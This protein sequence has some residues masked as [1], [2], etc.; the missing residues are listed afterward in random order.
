MLRCCWC[1]WLARRALLGFGAPLSDAGK[2]GR[3]GGP[4]CAVWLPPVFPCTIG[5]AR[6][7]PWCGGCGYQFSWWPVA[8][9][10]L[11]C[12]GH[13]ASTLIPASSTPSGPCFGGWAG[14]LKYRCT[15]CSSGGFCQLAT[16]RNAVCHLG[17]VGWSCSLSVSA[18]CLAHQH[19]CGS[20]CTCS[21]CWH[22]WRG[23][24]GFGNSPCTCTVGVCALPGGGC[25]GR[26]PAGRAQV[27]LSCSFCISRPD[28]QCQQ[29][30]CCSGR[31][32]CS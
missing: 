26:R 2:G 8:W 12:H 10:L 24:G 32:R 25:C 3:R 5:F 6:I 18:L 30:V 13:A 22:L 17:R 31:F 27:F 7:L 15:T 1:R 29:P 4:F 11:S 20:R 19:Q 23:A 28:H 9:R 14:W 16:G 21:S